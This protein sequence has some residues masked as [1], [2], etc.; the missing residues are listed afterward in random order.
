[1]RSFGN[2]VDSFLEANNH[3]DI[4]I[5]NQSL[6]YGMLAIQKRFPFIEIIHHPITMDLKHDL[7]Q[8]ENSCIGFLGKGG[9]H[10]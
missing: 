10:F 4:I 5:D 7:E 8:I 9:T 6:S 2:R 3:Y 1:M